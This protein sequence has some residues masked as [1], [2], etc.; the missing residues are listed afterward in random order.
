[1][2]LFAVAFAA[3][4]ALVSAQPSFDPVTNAYLV[5]LFESADAKVDMKVNPSTEAY[6]VGLFEA[7]QV[8]TSKYICG[9]IGEGVSKV[10][11]VFPE[12]TKKI[13][14]GATGKVEY[15]VESAVGTKAT[16][17]DISVADHAPVR[18]QLEDVDYLWPIWP[19]TVNVTGISIEGSPA[20]PKTVSADLSAH[21]ATLGVTIT[22]P[23][24]AGAHDATF[25]VEMFVLD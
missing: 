4:A 14:V 21:G 24:T 9:V 5:G 22:P 15:F 7:S 10:Q 25:K 6:L 23:S 1:M 20:A 16:A 12:G 2:K 18:R 11:L 17:C 19:K 8:L 13:E 3:L